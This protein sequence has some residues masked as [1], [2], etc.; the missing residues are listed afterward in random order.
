[1]GQM[2]MRDKEG[3]GLLE[4]SYQNEKCANEDIW[5]VYKFQRGYH[6]CERVT[7]YMRLYSARKEERERNDK[8]GEGAGY[9][10]VVFRM[11]RSSPKQRMSKKRNA[12]KR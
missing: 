1:M 7:D 8:I 11:H 12:R 3:N 2:S 9:S 5:A 4:P 6:E 10:F